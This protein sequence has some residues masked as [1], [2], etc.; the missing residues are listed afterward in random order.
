MSLDYEAIVLKI[1]IVGNKLERGKC[2]FQL[3]ITKVK[4]KKLHEVN[5]GNIND[6]IISLAF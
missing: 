3:V 1:E 6:H 2:I 5:T 4:S